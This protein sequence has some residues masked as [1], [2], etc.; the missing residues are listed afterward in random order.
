MFANRV[1]IDKMGVIASPAP[2]PPLTGRRSEATKQYGVSDAENEIAS[3]PSVAR[4]DNFRLFSHPAKR[5]DLTLVGCVCLAA[6]LAGCGVHPAATL[7]VTNAA[8]E[9]ATGS[10][11]ATVG[12]A[13]INPT[14]GP[15]EGSTSTPRPTLAPDAWKTLPTIP[16]FSERAMEIY[17]RGLALGR[18][19]NVFSKI[20]DCQ[21]ITTY[22][23][24]DFENPDKYRLG[25]YADLQP[26]I[27]WFKG[28]F[29]RKSLS[30]HGG[31]NVAAVL[32]PLWADPDSCNAGENPMACEL[33]VNNPG[34]VIISE[35][36]AWSG[37]VAK[38]GTYLRQVIEYTI[39]QGVVPILAT[40]ADNL[41]GGNRIDALIA[42][43][44]WEYDIP[45]WNFWGSVQWL[46]T[47]GLSQDGFHL[48]QGYNFK[49]YFFDQ[50][51][52]DWSGWMERNL[53]ALQVLDAARRELDMQSAP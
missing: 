42:G 35:E 44:A 50:P 31:M 20:G 1:Q 45:L 37:D 14:I 48:T 38:Y 8:T 2:A 47:H 52:A 19:P 15:T 53:T 3:L 28:S 16:A 24:A 46:P 51:S 5:F 26:T 33:R 10:G 29:G 9:A 39:A 43:L 18:N 27:D 41:E 11:A 7:P 34:I 21:N 17:R 22:F 49:N 30:V 23:L 13:T 25:Q 32:S 4:N 40:K 36:E 6:A 12:P